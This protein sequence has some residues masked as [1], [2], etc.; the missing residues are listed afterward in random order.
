MLLRMSLPIN[1]HLPFKFV[2]IADAILQKY[3]II[4]ITRDCIE[5]LVE[6]VD[7]NV[8]MDHVCQQPDNYY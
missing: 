6:I 7:E 4:T 3:D 8:V 1:I 5:D 2:N